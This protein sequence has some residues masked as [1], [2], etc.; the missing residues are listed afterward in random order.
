[1]PDL[2]V[3]LQETIV[4]PFVA[5]DTEGV[6]AGIERL[7]G[8]LPDLRCQSDE[9]NAVG[10]VLADFLIR[11]TLAHGDDEARNLIAKTFFLAYA[12]G[13]RDPYIE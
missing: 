10:A 7:C 4:G 1:M 12:I 9:C 2:T 3:M 8:E 13:R 11:H 5:G 6:D